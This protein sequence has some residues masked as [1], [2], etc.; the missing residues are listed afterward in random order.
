[1]WMFVARHEFADAGEIRRV[2]MSI[3][4]MPVRHLSDGCYARRFD[5]VR[6]RRLRGIE[7]AGHAVR[8]VDLYQ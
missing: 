6:E 2:V 3:W 7:E 4:R 8:V 5:I 1:M